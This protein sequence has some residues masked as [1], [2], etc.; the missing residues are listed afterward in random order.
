MS[1]TETVILGGAECDYDPKRRLARVYCR[2]CSKRNETE[3]WIKD[4]QPVFP[5][6]ICIWCGAWN[7]PEC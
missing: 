2:N 4:G 5:G 6:F 7:G 1:F 3:V